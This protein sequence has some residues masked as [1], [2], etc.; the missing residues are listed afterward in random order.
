[1]V[2]NEAYVEHDEPVAGKD[3]TVNV[4]VE[5]YNPMHEDAAAR[6]D[7]YHGIPIMD[8]FA[9]STPTPRGGSAQL[10]MR[11]IAGGDTPYSIY[12]VM[13]SERCPRMHDPANNAG[14][15]HQ[16]HILKRPWESKKPPKFDLSCIVDDFSDGDA[17]HDPPWT[18]WVYASGNYYQGVNGQNWG[19]YLLGPGDNTTGNAIPIPGSSL[20][21]TL[22]RKQMQFSVPA[23]G[24]GD[25]F[26]PTI[27]LRRLLCPHLPPNDDPRG[28]A[29]DDP[30]HPPSPYNPYITVDYVEDVHDNVTST[31]IPKRYSVGR[32]QPYA[33]SGGN[34]NPQAANPPRTDQ[35]QHTFFQHNSS[36]AATAAS[37]APELPPLPDAPPRRLDFP[38]GYQPAFDWLVHLDRE[39]ISPMELLHVSG[40]KP[41][42]LTERFMA[43]GSPTAHCVPWF[44]GQNR[45]FRLFEYL[46]C[47]GRMAG[48]G[49]VTFAGNPAVKAG[50]LAEVTLTVPPE[51]IDRTLSS[52]E[53][54]VIGY[55]PGG[56]SWGGGGA[57][58]R[59]V[60]DAGTS[61]EEIVAWPAGSSRDD[62]FRCKVA[63][64]KDHDA[65]FR[66]SIPIRS[67]RQP[68]KININTIWDVETFRALCDAQ[69]PNA[70]Y[71]TA[72]KDGIPDAIFDLIKDADPVLN[73]IGSF[74]PARPFW[75]TG[76]GVYDDRSYQWNGEGM[77]IGRTLL[78]AREATKSLGRGDPTKPR[79]FEVA[80]LKAAAAP[81]ANH[82]YRRYELLTK[83]Y[84]NTTIRSNVFAVW[85]T[86]GFFEVDDQGRLGAEIRRADGRQQRH[87]FFAIV[88]RSAL[89]P[90]VQLMG[91]LMASHNGAAATFDVAAGIIL[92]S[93]QITPLDPPPRLPLLNNSQW[94]P[95]KDYSLVRM[96]WPRDTF[97]WP[98]GPPA[99][100]L[101]STVIE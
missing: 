10:Q 21:N 11:S 59:V 18:E 47:G 49:C 33:A 3:T 39:V 90:W 69:P 77:G 66:V 68:G 98:T 100:V 4:W 72:V 56:G 45:L 83:I 46:E 85:C 14:T 99:T 79:L 84:N 27:L 94:D 13:L 53:T 87:R 1:L 86:V 55:L 76:V 51:L 29:S 16:H 93:N 60:I 35:P 64:T 31:P 44:D 2:V 92:A 80:G 61:K 25:D 57:W 15:P 36:G 5:L 50:S 6:A 89:E 63:F 71:T 37:Q 75:S 67:P 23:G 65:N 48:L 26:K 17:T 42:Q 70:F 81:G 22:S 43:D 73:P 52:P 95:S 28:T 12:Q 96:P 24:S 91:M 30:R 97:L 8:P 32:R 62:P 58:D 38:A 9:P 34:E 19:F 101:Y 20:R 78:G 74:V 40:Y 88:D 54:G 7:W 82:P 41:Y